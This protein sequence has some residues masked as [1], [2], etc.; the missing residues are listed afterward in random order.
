V[1]FLYLKSRGLYFLLTSVANVSPALTFEILN[2]ITKLIKDYCGILSED[3]IRTNFVLIYEI[4]DEIMDAGYVQGTS[5]ENLKAF[6]YNEP[7]IT[8]IPNNSTLPVPNII[9]NAVAGTRRSTP[10][11]AAMRP[12]ISARTESA[13]GAGSKGD[14]QNELFVDLV[15]QMTVLFGAGGNILRSELDG[16]IVI[17]S[18]LKGNPEVRLAL[19]EDLILS[20][21]T[22][23]YSYGAA[24]LDD[25]NFHECANTQLFETEKTI[26]FTPPEGEFALM[27]YRISSDFR[28]PF[29]LVPFVEDFGGNKIEVSLKVRADLPDANS[30]NNVIIKIPVPKNAQ[31][32][33]G[34]LEIGVVGQTVEYKQLEN[35]VYWS[36]KKFKGSSEQS[37][38]VRIFMQDGANT[39]VAKKEVGPINVEFDIPMV[40]SSNIQIRFLRVVERNRTYQPHR[41]IRYITLSK[42][43]IYRVW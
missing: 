2:R 17:K 32:V 41:W 39:A 6:I 19:N 33:Q 1:N 5:T 11:T 35:M 25:F 24:A 31:S 36:I 29:R 28:I 7:I 43:Y 22:S 8:G 21:A 13:F 4:L 27:N 20:G 40:N 3:S 34:I 23:A 14:Q 18:Y 12:V 16:A 10:S 9:T 30:G 26:V 37:L 15:E 38:R 42:S